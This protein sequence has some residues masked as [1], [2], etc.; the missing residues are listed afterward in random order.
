MRRIEDRHQKERRAES[1]IPRPMWLTHP[2]R[3]QYEGIVMS[4]AGD[5]PGYFNLWRGFAVEPKPGDW[6]RLQ[7]AHLRRDLRRGRARIFNYV[8]HGWHSA[9]QHPEQPAEVAL[10]LRGT[11]HREGNIR[12]RL[13]RTV[14]PALPPDRQHQ[15]P[16]RQFQRASAGC[17][18]CCSRTKRSGRA[19][20]PARAC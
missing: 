17:S 8:V 4:P 15:T 1:S 3:R 7:D 14:R 20:K 6:S 9:S 11:W 18:S 19:T 16:D 13:R 5:V 10:A 2:D 12:P